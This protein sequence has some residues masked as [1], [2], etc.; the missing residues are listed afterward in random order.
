MTDLT[1]FLGS[2]SKL[3]APLQYSF[4]GTVQP[5]SFARFLVRVPQALI[6]FGTFVL[7]VGNGIPISGSLSLTASSDGTTGTIVYR[8]HR[9]AG[10]CRRA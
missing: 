7:P 8:P 2:T 5:N 9:A 10:R 3:G 1:Q 4:D 6:L